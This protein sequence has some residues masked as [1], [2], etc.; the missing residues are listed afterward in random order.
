M[1]SLAVCGSA[2]VLVER[3]AAAVKGGVNMVQLREKDLAGGELLDLAR[4]L[5]VAIAGKALLFVN[6]RVDVAL[7]CGAE[8][9]QLGEKA[10][11]VEAVRR[12]GGD[13]LLIG[14]SVHSLEGALEAAATRADLLTVG[15]IFE[16][17]S[18]PG[19]PAAGVGLVRSIAS[20]VTLPLIGI[21]GIEAEN[22]AQV[23]AAGASGVA[24]IRAVLGA[25]DP[26]AA[27]RRLWEAISR[28]R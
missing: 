20:K 27:A 15:T 9:V 19:T 25:H 18:H 7:A 23:M 10:L 13:R 17:A 28:V 5:K 3:V 24:V 8:G 26:E 16:T 2:S 11:P 14:R 21:G 12:I 22:A 6:D 1:T 4:R